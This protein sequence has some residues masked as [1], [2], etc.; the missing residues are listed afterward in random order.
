[1]NPNRAPVVILISGRGTNLQAIVD[2]RLPIDIRAVVSNN[3]NA[4]GLA[5]A[6]RAGLPVEI[7]D[8]RQFPDRAA[9]DRALGDCIARYAPT[10]VLLAG[11]MRILGAEFIDRFAGR[12]INIHPSLLPA[13][14]GLDTHARALAAGVA[15]HGATVHFV[16][17]EVDGGPVIAQARVRVEPSD[18]AA[19][20]AARV[21]AAEHALYPQAIR[22]VVSGAVRLENGRV[23]HAARA[24]A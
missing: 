9:F 1:M 23:V 13:F 19:S 11:F 2:A 21:L 16:T 7:I 3:A 15:E 17:H 8:H 12:L 10:W 4:P 18:D 14:P 6:T 5:I 24:H 22:A 20:L